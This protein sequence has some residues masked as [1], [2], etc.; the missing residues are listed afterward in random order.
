MSPLAM[1]RE[2]EALRLE[3]RTVL[4]SVETSQ[5]RLMTLDHTQRRIEGLSVK[6]QDLF[7]ESTRC[8]ESQLHR[9][10]FVM[11]WAA[12]IDFVHEK[13]AEDGL[14]KLREVRPKWRLRAVEDL[15]EQ[16]DYQMI[17]AASDAGLLRR[18][19]KRAVQ[20]LL[21]RRNECA[22]PEDF[23]PGLNESLGYISELLGRVELL[24]SRRVA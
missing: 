16:S 1:L 2:L 24:G 6:Q 15:R 21:S 3:C 18:A 8:V 12:F 17:E 11:A 22:H 14:V 20:G 13:L 10:A 5:D 23:N 7:R 19:E 9:A 4:A